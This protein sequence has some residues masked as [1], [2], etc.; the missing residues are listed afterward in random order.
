MTN[1][2]ATFD[3]GATVFELWTGVV[4]H[5]ELLEHARRQFADPG[6]R[7]GTIVFADA[8]SAT[9]ET[10]ADLVHEFTEEYGRETNRAR[11]SK[12]GVLVAPDAWDRAQ[13]FAGQAKECGVAV[14]IFHSLDVAC[15]WLGLDP[16]RVEDGMRHLGE[17]MRD[18]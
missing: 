15:T 2:Y 14:I 9:F 6:I 12:C 7:P 5:E 13:L 4:T 1:R 3:D 8:R 17:L 16:Q 10:N 18:A 11:T